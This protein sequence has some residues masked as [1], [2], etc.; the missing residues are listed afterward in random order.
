MNSGLEKEYD[1]PM[2]DVNAFLNVRDTRIG[3]SKFAI[4]K[5]SNNKGPFSKRKDYVIFDKILT[6]E[7]S[8]YTT[9]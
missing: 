2:D 9:K 7:V 3:P 6:F 8:E 4:K 1:L 5:Y